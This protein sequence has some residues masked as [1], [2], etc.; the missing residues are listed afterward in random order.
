MLCP[1]C[2]ETVPIWKTRTLAVVYGEGEELD[3]VKEI[4]FT[5][6]IN[7]EKNQDELKAEKDFYK[8]YRKLYKKNMDT[9]D[10]RVADLDEL[11][12]ED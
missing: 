5:D 7:S 3:L 9:I 8:A 10:E 4:H 1:H 6:K 12:E 2:G 11:I